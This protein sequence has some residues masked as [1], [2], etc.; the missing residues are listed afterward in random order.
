MRFFG[1]VFLII[2][3]ILYLISL[4]DF[5]LFLVPGTCLF[6]LGGLIISWGGKSQ[7]AGQG[8]SR[9]RAKQIRRSSTDALKMVYY[10]IIGL[11]IAEA[12][13]RT[14]LSDRQFLGIQVL[15]WDHLPTFLLLI[16]F[17][18]TICRFLHGASIHL[19]ALLEKRYNPLVDFIEFFLQALFF[20]LMAISLDRPP[21][22]V[23]LLILML[24]SD[25]V[26]LF[27][28]KFNKYVDFKR[29]QK[30]WLGSDV[31]LIIA[32]LLLSLTYG[33][34]TEIPHALTVMTAAIMAA[35]FDYKVNKD[36]YFP[37]HEAKEAA[38]D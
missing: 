20:Y 29:T 6:V 36:F 15:C 8:L 18:V 11:A 30:Q 17:L 1:Y 14:F 23:V 9:E 7:E 25:L 4:F 21:E 2:G 32:F 3:I 38:Q 37:P 19:I 5:F 16:A 27:F 13:G 35:V 31:F 34:I 28:L 33:A 26:W 24:T 10:V 22:F 12:L